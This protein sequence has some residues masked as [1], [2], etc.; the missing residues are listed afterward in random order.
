MKMIRHYNAQRMAKCQ[1]T[2]CLLVKKLESAVF[3]YVACL[4]VHQRRH[5]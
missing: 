2:M 5:L 1:I 3:V 4:T